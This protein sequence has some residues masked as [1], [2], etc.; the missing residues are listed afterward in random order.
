MIYNIVKIKPL[1]NN[2]YNVLELVTKDS[3]KL[4]KDEF[5]INSSIFEHLYNSKQK[6]MSIYF[7]IED[8]KD[9]KYI[10]ISNVKILSK[11]MDLINVL[12]QFYLSKIE[13]LFNVHFDTPS[14]FSMYETVQISNK[15][16]EYNIFINDTNREE[17]Y[18]NIINK[19][20]PELLDLLQIYLENKDKLDKSLEKFNKFH[21]LS[22]KINKS[23]TI[24]ELTEVW[25][26][27]KL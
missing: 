22:S 6:G 23:Q 19:N 24:E 18:I 21:D 17:E 10:Q 15:F 9:I 4:G 25:E 14:M 5:I 8:V 7:L 3:S 20:C 12:K 16:A 27:I 1:N 11:D 13:G 26:S 2:V